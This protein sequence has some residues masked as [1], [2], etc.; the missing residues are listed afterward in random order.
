VIEYHKI[1][2]VFLRDPANRHKTFLLGQYSL[3]VFEYL[4][5]NQWVWTE[6]I[7]GTNVRVRWDG[8]DVE[9]GGRTNDAQMPVFLMQRLQQIFTPVALARVFPDIKDGVQV[10][11]FGEGY[12]A[13]IQKAGGLY[14]PDGCDFILFDVMVNGLYLERHNVDD[15]AVQLQI[16]SVPELG[17]GTLLEAIERVKEGFPSMIGKAQAEGMVLRPVVELTD[18]LGHRVITKVKH[19]DFA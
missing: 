6:K 7:D 9:F 18:R 12:G 17:R 2:S 16:E 14:K 19:R 4:A 8:T 13:K 15:I 10:I 3:P 1:Q 11:L 5:G